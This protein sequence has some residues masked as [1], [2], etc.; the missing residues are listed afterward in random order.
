MFEPFPGNYVWN[1][2]TNLALVCGG[3]HG[4]VDAAC[5]PIREAAARGED[6]GTA[7]LFDSWI[8]VADQVARN[9]EADE[10]AGRCTPG[11]WRLAGCMSI[12]SI[13]LTR[14]QPFP[15]FSCMTA[16]VRESPAWCPAM[17]WTA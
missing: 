12:L 14:A 16:A 13:F 6:A 4:E 1:L 17:G 3:N 9:A 7:L 11:M 15:P 5:R 10:A 8:A 2:Q